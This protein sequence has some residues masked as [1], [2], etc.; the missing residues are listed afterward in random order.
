MFVL[1][2]VYKSHLVNLGQSCKSVFVPVK[3]KK[4]SEQFGGANMISE[5]SSAEVSSAKISGG[6]LEIKGVFPLVWMWCHTLH[7]P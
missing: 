6:I 7:S 2:L 1:E 3:S 5:I 4:G